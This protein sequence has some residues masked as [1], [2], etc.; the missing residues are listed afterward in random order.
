MMADN[1]W[2]KLL[3]S[4]LQTFSPNSYYEKRVKL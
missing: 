1:A 3:T 2:L 4:K